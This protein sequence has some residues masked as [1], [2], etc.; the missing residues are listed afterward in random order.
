M[1]VRIEWIPFHR[2]WLHRDSSSRGVEKL[3]PTTRRMDRSRHCRWPLALDASRY[4]GMSQRGPHLGALDKRR[5]E[6]AAMSRS[7]VA[8]I[9]TILLLI[10]IGIWIGGSW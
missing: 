7:I 9:I 6:R 4:R 1:C 3:E 8:S 10:T 5:I 2:G